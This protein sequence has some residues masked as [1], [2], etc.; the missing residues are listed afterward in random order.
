MTRGK[1]ADCE[2]W[3]SCPGCHECLEVGAVKIY[4]PGIDDMEEVL[5][6]F[7]KADEEIRGRAEAARKE[8]DDNP[9]GEVG[10]S[11]AKA[12]TMAKWLKMSTRDE[13]GSEGAK[14]E[15]L[16]DDDDVDVSSI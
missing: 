7:D 15:L 12:E 11:P 8:L 14:G 2:G 13:G 3:I 10:D 16:G 4:L 6:A 5:K 9:S 1:D